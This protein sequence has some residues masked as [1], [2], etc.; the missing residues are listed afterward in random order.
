[1]LAPRISKLGDFVQAANR[2]SGWVIWCITKQ[3]AE[4]MAWDAAAD[5]SQSMVI[6]PKR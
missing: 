6:T 4:P 1:V 5:C 2:V 3:R